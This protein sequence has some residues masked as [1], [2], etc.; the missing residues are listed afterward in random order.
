MMQ[1]GWDKKEIIETRK[2]Y[3]NLEKQFSNNKDHLSI[4]NSR[5]YNETREYYNLLFEILTAPNG[6]DIKQSNKELLKIIREEYAYEEEINYID[7]QIILSLQDIIQKEETMPDKLILSQTNFTDKEKIELVG[8]MIQSK[9]TKE[10][11]LYFKNLFI[12]NKNHI[13][14]SDTI[15]SVFLY[16]SYNNDRHV[17][18]E[19]CNNISEI[20]DIAHEAGHN[21]R[22]CINHIRTLNDNDIVGEVE[23]MWYEILMGSYL[24]EEGVYKDDAIGLITDTFSS[25]EKKTLVSGVCLRND[26]QSIKSIQEFTKMAQEYNL[27]EKTNSNSNTDLLSLIYKAKCEATHIY[28]YSLLVVLELLEIYKQDKKRGI[29]CYENFVSRLDNASNYSLVK[30]LNNDYITFNNLNNY[31]KYRQKLLRKVR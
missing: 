19:K 15:D 10:H 27:Y 11:Y 29:L 6:E 16:N 5:N 7:K 28:M 26:I 17:I 30:E 18:I 2:I 1:Y 4:K 12:D 31:K 21:Y 25:V 24:I 14:F 23:S 8:D 13:L 3:Y 9:L 22:N 20:L